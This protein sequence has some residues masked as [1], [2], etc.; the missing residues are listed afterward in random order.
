MVF[1]KLKS[2]NAFNSNEFVKASALMLLYERVPSYRQ[3]F[4]KI[5]PYVKSEI[6]KGN[7]I[8]S[9]VVKM[10][11]ENKIDIDLSITMDYFKMFFI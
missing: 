1:C 7:N 2:N 3:A 10:F 6:N 4:K 11:K 5:E 8:L 9:A